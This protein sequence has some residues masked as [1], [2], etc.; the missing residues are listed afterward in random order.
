MILIDCELSEEEQAFTL[1]HEFA[2]IMLNHCETGTGVF[3]E[4]WEQREKEPDNYADKM[5]D[6]LFDALLSLSEIIYCKKT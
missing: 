6:S 5:T 4:G 3:G 1:R 2:H